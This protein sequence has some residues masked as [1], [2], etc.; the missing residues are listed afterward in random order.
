VVTSIASPRAL[1]FT[2]L[3]LAA[4]HAM[5]SALVRPL[6]QVSDEVN[7]LASIQQVALA[8][9]ADPGLRACLSPP[10]G[11]LPASMP[12][13]GKR[14]FHLAGAA[15][16]TRACRAGSGP[17][18]PLGVRLVLS[19]TL[20]VITW[21][22]WQ[23]ARLLREGTWVP[24][25]AAL[26]LA[27]QPVLA[28]YSGAITPDSLANASAAVAVT[29]AVRTVVRGPGPWTLLG[30][31]VFTALAAAF[32]DAALVLVPV[33]GA[34]I[35]VS[36]WWWL[37]G[38]GRSASSRA[39]AV[40]G[41]LLLGVVAA[42]T[43]TT[44]D[45]G[46]GIARAL[47]DPLTFGSR[48]VHDLFLQ[49]PGFLLSSWTSLGG[50]GGHAAPMPRAAI[51]IVVASWAIAAVGLA[52]LA[53]LPTEGRAWWAVGYLTLLV[54]ACVLQAPIRQI[55]LD[56]ADTHQGRWLFPVAVPFAVALASGLNAALARRSEACWPLV[57]L[58]SIV[59]MTLA[60]TSVVQWHVASP[61]WDLDTAHLFLYATGG[62]DID[63]ERV[64]EQVRGAWPAARGLVTSLT[65]IALACGGLLMAGRPV[66]AES[67]HVRHPHDC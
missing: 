42:G 45:V 1:L 66:P 19:M 53:L 58:G 43:R 4:L 9:A 55:L 15:V 39:L 57:A 37:G 18:A 23:T 33:H 13:G 31:L 24:A 30:V 32:K 17:W 67:S 10:D 62:L 40:A 34:L 3:L 21:A 28:K 14:L 41:L 47:A 54:T 65:V 22:G 44:Y 27:T 60:L 51:V 6:Y 8:T 56:M 59:V 46:P 11:S 5:V 61:A 49:L 35:A 16:L 12:A 20:V 2:L 64:A 52:R 29:L 26:S 38:R 25:V 36:L 50:F 63:P 7:Y 48:V